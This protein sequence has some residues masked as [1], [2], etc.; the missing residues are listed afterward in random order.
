MSDD[1]RI[2]SLNDHPDWSRPQLIQILRQV[3]E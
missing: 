3:N 1:A 2:I